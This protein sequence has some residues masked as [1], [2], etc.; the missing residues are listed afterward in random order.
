MSK[1]ILSILLSLV[2]MISFM[3]TMAFAES[4][5]IDDEAKLNV[6]I[7]SANAGDTIKLDGDITTKSP[8][9]INKNLTLDL[10]GKKIDRGL[11]TATA[12]GS[13]IIVK[14]DAN[15]TINDK[16][17]GK[18][19]KITGGY[20]TKYGGGIYIEKGGVTL[21]AGSITQNKAN[22]GGGVYNDGA[23]TIS[24]GNISYNTAEN[25]GGG[26]YNNGSFTMTGG[27]IS[28]NTSDKNGGGVY[29]YKNV[30]LGGTAVIKDN[31]VKEKAENLFLSQKTYVDILTGSSAPTTGMS[32]GISLYDSEGT[33]TTKT[34]LKYIERYFFADN[35][36]ATISIDE[37]EST[38]YITAY[39]AVNFDMQGHG[40]AIN[41][42]VVKMGEL[43]KAPTDPTDT[44]YDFGGWYKEKTF[45]SKWDFAKSKVYEDTT[46][47]AKW[48]PSVKGMTLSKVKGQTY[49][50]KAI[51]PAITATFGTETLVLNK[52]YKVEY[53]DNTKVGTASVIVTG[54]G[55][56]TGSKTIEFRINPKNT[57]IKSLTKGYKNFTVNVKKLSSSKVTGYQLRYSRYSDMAGSKTKTIGKK[58]NKTTRT[59]SKLKS[60]KNY[61]VQVRAYKKVN[62]KNY[63]STWS[64][65]K[66]V[67]TL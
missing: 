35:T 9:V 14:D 54:I 3:P 63:Y 15:L 39:F 55:N 12:D 4:T 42:Q 58:Y 49:T 48:T 32:V 59:V 5:T 1:K 28:N 66:K 29:A 26:V 61:Y 50:G 52:D 21:L 57:S 6:A 30:S 16:S 19:G 56:Y 46:L 62:G 20:T 11:K 34:D 65:A 53:K 33:F 24:G 31:K 37:K 64:K 45:T 60:K 22:Y 44:A 43:A 2:M 27:N 10:N 25:E 41:K 36:N 13:V 47:Y 18:L 17:T 23:L 38:Y 40:T 7:N 51:T 67:K 8:V